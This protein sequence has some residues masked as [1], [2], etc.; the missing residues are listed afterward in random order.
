MQGNPVAVSFLLMCGLPLAL[1]AF[2][3]W[4]GKGRPL[5]GGRR[6]VFGIRQKH[7]GSIEDEY[8]N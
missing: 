6:I 5:P 3:Y 4:L 2:G 8:D 7:G 1:V